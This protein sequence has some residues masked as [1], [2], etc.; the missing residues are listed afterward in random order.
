MVTAAWKQKR[1]T[2]MC[3]AYRKTVLGMAGS[4]KSDFICPK[5]KMLKR[6][7]NTQNGV[8]PED[9]GRTWQDTE[10]LDPRAHASADRIYQNKE[11]KTGHAQ[12]PLSDEACQSSDLSTCIYF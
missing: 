1:E 12:C 7:T 6:R 10:P 8:A 9:R 11:N 3:V 5:P 4:R 2:L